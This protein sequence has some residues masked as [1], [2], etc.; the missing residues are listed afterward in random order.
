[1]CRAWSTALA[2]RPGEAG[3]RASSPAV[4]SCPPVVPA[5]RGWLWPAITA[6][7][8][9]PVPGVS[10]GPGRLAAARS[11]TAA[12]ASRTRAS[13]TFGAIRFFTA[14]L[15]G[16]RRRWRS[17]ALVPGP[18][19]PGTDR[20]VTRGRLAAPALLRTFIGPCVVGGA[21]PT[22]PGPAPWPAPH[23]GL[24]GRPAG[25]PSSGAHAG[26]SARWHGS[27]SYPHRPPSA[28]AGNAQS[29]RSPETVLRRPR[30]GEHLPSHPASPAH[31]GDRGL[32]VIAELLR[33]PL[34]APPATVGTQGRSSG[35]ADL[36][37]AGHIG[38]LQRRR[39]QRAGPDRAGAATVPQ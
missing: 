21:G 29:R 9:A 8:A 34:R 7:G 30:C 26:S 16:Y 25:P 5:G 13:G 24:A 36:I 12:T 39:E 22:G 3:S 2:G 11:A 33:H 32:R 6:T 35:R 4:P 14:L 15:L 23:R 10:G 38:A 37:R 18:V 20:A 1:M 19:C 28:Q 31:P 17:R 27:A